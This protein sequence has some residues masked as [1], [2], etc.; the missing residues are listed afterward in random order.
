MKRFTLLFSAVLM[1]FTACTLPYDH[2]DI[3]DRLDKL[4][5]EVKNTQA[6]LAALSNNLTITSV[7]ESTEGYTITFSDN[8][9]IVVKH[10]KDGEDG[11]NGTDG[12]DGKDGED[13]TSVIVSVTWDD[14]NAYFTLS[15]GTVVTIPLS[16]DAGDDN[17]GGDNTGGDNNLPVGA[18]D[19]VINEV[20]SA[21]KYIELYNKSTTEN[22]DLGGWTIR[23]NNEGAI[24]DQ[25][26]LGEFFITDGTILP[27]GG[28]AVIN[29]KGANNAH[30]ALNLGVSNSGVSGKKSLLLELVNAAGERVDYFVN[31]ANATPNVADAW[32]GAIEHQFDVACRM[33]DGGEW[34]VVDT[35]TIGAANAGNQTAQFVNTEVNFTP[36]EGGDD[37]TGENPSTPTS[38][39][40]ESVKYVWNEETFPKITLSVSES[41][42]NRMLST[43]DQNNK[44][45]Q[46]FK[47]NVTFDN[48]TEV[49]TFEEAGWRLR[50]NTSRRRPEVGSNTH[51]RNNAD[52]QHFHTQLN[53]RK[54]HKD[55]AHTIGGVRKMYL[56]WHK[57]DPMYVREMYCY[58][59]FRRYGVWTAINDI[60][61]RLWIHVEGDT[62]PA[63]Y[64]VYEMQETVDDEYLEV[65]SDKFGGHKGNLWKCSYTSDGP[66]TLK[67]STDAHQSHLFGLDVDTDQEWTYEL[68]TDNYSFDSAKS[69][70]V[71]FM[72]K[73]ENKS[74]EELKVWLEEVIDIPL[75]LKTYAV[76]VTVGMWDDYWNNGNNYY[77]YFN[78]GSTSGYKFYF[79]PYDYDNSLGTSASCMRL[80]D[81]GR[82]TPLKWGTNAQ[83]PLIN[84][85]LECDPKYKELYVNYLKELID[86]SAGYFYYE[87]SM[88]RIR[89]WHNKIRDYVSNDTGEDMSIYDQPASWSN[90]GE[91]RLLENSSNNFFKVKADSYR[92][93]HLK[94]YY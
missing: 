28:Y 44:T 26:G 35:A 37:N 79:I 24:A 90:H 87:A 10:G 86:S 59:L 55:D 18:G 74:G 5:E 75:L 2:S 43:F 76:N 16:A 36:S 91:Y 27:A 68:K 47:G 20:N 46:Y 77:M 69:Q 72:Y 64:G 32:D 63:Y 65:R 89:N 33:P 71:D 94:S 1:L 45:K 14:E 50:G 34:Y 11:E 88:A 57:D 21:A 17:T 7:T 6:L 22:V 8:S 81:S 54:Y 61:C 15:D 56:K 66:A 31:S 9:Q 38:S 39:L 70:L 93:N 62:N 48:G 41:E 29:C 58:D 13:G 73:L 3:L 67:H 85:V 4:E 82:D 40:A 51:R 42:W 49:Y 19:V 83:H 80:S 92:N 52:W 84:K 53:L 23:K 60:Y 30:N 25:S 78:A 12:E